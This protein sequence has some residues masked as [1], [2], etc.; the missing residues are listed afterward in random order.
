MKQKKAKVNEFGKL[1]TP[2]LV[3]LILILIIVVVYPLLNVFQKKSFQTTV[4]SKP[5]TSKVE[6][7]GD[8]NYTINF[9]IKKASE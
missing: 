9:G 6:V 1:E 4:M 7:S 3:L 8:S 2:L 5:E